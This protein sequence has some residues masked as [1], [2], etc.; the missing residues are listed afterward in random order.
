MK[1]TGKK[2]IPYQNLGLSLVFSL[3]CLGAGIALHDSLSLHAVVQK[4]GIPLVRLLLL[5]FIGLLAGQVI[6][7]LGWT[8][9]MAVVARPFF[10]FS[11]LG[12]RCGAA[13]TSAF[14]SGATAN[15]MLLDFYEDQK[16]TKMQ[17]FLTNYVNQFPAYFLHLPTTFFI[18]LPLTGPAGALYFAL[19]FLAT[20]IRTVCFL[21]FGRI[22][23]TLPDG[24]A[25]TFQAARPSGLGWT[26]DFS[27]VIDAVKTKLP[28]R[29]L[30]IFVWV[31]P[32]YTLVFLLNVFGVFND[33]NQSLARTVTLSIMP[34][35]SLSVVILSF[36]AEFTSGF[37]AAGALMEAGILTTKQTVMALLLGNVLAFPIRALRHQLPRYM[38]IFSPKMGLQ[39][40][41]SGQL[42]RVVS[43]LLVGIL[44]YMV[45]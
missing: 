44:Y 41:L 15:A 13:F 7:T 12:Q 16:I 37:A 26:S 39:L 30:H 34:V 3:I 21:V 4:L 25:G 10:A 17:L 5:I 20:L 1:P 27:R 40:L 33:L 2:K 32:I 36:A 38:G 18:V 42:F 14:I 35:E 6:E 43:I 45:A 24:K 29:I 22:F 9:Q 28:M 8:R 23:L 11:R 19:T 31:L